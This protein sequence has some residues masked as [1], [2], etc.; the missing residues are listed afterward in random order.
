MQFQFPFLK[1]VKVR[2]PFFIRFNQEKN[3]I[4]EKILIKEEEKNNNQQFL[5]TVNKFIK[6]EN[7]KIYKRQKSK[8]K[9]YSYIII[10]IISIISYSICYKK[11]I[12]Q[13]S[14]VILK[15]S[16]GGKHN[17]FYKNKNFTWPNRVLI[18]GTEQSH[19]NYTY[20]LYEG[21]VVKLIWNKNITGC[22]HMFRDCQSI[23]EIIFTNF[24]TSL[25]NYMF[26]M[27]KNCESLK[28]LDLS[29]FDTSNVERME[30]MFS[31]CYSLTSL[32]IKNFNTIKVYNMGHMFN[33]C[34]SL[35]SIDL[36][37]FHTPNVNAS[38]NMFNGCENLT[39]INVSSFD[40]SS[41]ARIAKMFYN[42]LSLKYIDM[43]NLNI[44]SNMEKMENI[45][46]N[47]D[48]LEFINLKNFEMDMNIDI[49]FFNRTSK[50]LVICTKNQALIDILEPD[51][52]ISI[53]CEDNWYDY[54]VKINLENN[55]CTKNCTLT[56]FKYE[57]NFKCL[58]RCLKGTYDYNYKCI[59]PNSQIPDMYDIMLR[60]IEKDFTSIYYNTSLLERGH[61]DIIEF[62][63]LKVTLTTTKNQRERINNGNET[64]IDLRECENILR[65]EY[66]IPE[67]EELY[68][69]KIDASEE[70]MKI[71]KVEYDIY[72][73]LNGTNLV[74][75]NSSYCSNTKI[76]IYFPVNLKENLDQYDSRSKYYND[77][78]CSSSSD[79]GADI[80]LSDRKKE[81]I[82]KNKTICQ[83]DCFLSEYDNNIQQA[84][85]SCDVKE[86]SPYFS[87]MKINKAKL[88]DNFINVKNIINI[89]ILVCYKELFSKTGLLRNYGCYLTIIIIFMHFIIIILFYGNNIFKKIKEKID[90]I[91][92]GIKHNKFV[93]IKE[94]KIIKLNSKNFH[95]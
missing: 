42:C 75:L 86:S 56:N 11:M 14:S 47:C 49:N 70:G 43:P 87:K 55:S 15:F 4:D 92:I 41:L 74:K 51:E 64:Y 17:V 39:S 25:C 44:S 10:F 58:Q 80:I 46:L 73:K 62:G 66:N 94:K 35:K 67:N 89:N 24:N 85:C 57:Y 16:G 8:I 29:N 91:S 6:K 27:F 33:N 2:K 30:S 19:V 61:N 37:S 83:D 78:C 3:K 95:L 18:N 34:S 69:K 48:N 21:D 79:S 9:F 52:C 7:K 68:I 1:K 40:T 28:S 36:S 5:N 45:F 50:Y 63:Q 38:D 54:K 26:Q 12:S 13:E 84:K 65:K 90:Y 22:A 20:N 88:I 82:D 23:T 81:F 31:N 60:H 72:S 59:E 71:P 53:S 76:D 32:N 77:L 93:T